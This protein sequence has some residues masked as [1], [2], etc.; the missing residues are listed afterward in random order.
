[1][2]R[3][4]NDSPLVKE[5]T[6][7][8]VGEVAA[9]LGYSPHGAARSLI[10]SRTSTIGVLLPDLYGEFFSEVIR[11]I[12]QT[13]QHHGYHLLV[14]SSHDGRLALEAAL[15]SMR[16]RV[17]GLIVMW[18]EMDADIAVRN[19]PAGFPVVLLNSPASAD[20]FDV[21]MI[22]NFDGA[23]AMVC[24]LLDLGHKRIAIIKGAEGNVDAAER[25][26]GYRAALAEAGVMAL[27][28]LEVAG[29]FNEE[30]GFRAT[31]ELMLCKARPSAIFA[32]N[33]AMAIGALSAL[34]QAGLRVP[35]D[36]ALAGFDDIPMARYLD[37]ALSSV[38][39]DISALGARAA[40]RLLAAI[41]DKDGHQHRAE[42][43]PTTLVLRRSCGAAVPASRPTAPTAGPATLHPTPS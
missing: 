11:G 14:S 19:L 26:R 31:G 23:R 3:V 4:C 36:V 29:D 2:S 24:H 21:I 37:P 5:G 42:T 17:D 32:A 8:H 10:T 34:R 1:V 40:L 9:R 12:D 7:Q 33:D 22:A 35:E 18:P 15:R 27:P 25:L 20:L 39:V 43:L 6:C 28:E 16:G 41:R 38:H 13:A 30:S